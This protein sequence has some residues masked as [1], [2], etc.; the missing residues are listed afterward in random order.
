MIFFIMAQAGLGELIRDNL[1]IKGYKLPTNKILKIPSYVEDNTFI[2]TEI[3][4]V[5]LIMETINICSK[6]SGE[7]LNMDKKECLILGE[8]ERIN[9]KENM[10][11][12]K[13]EIKNIMTD[14]Q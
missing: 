12:V 3:G 2:S 13:P 9:F 8:W 6:A 11:W 1:N 4:L 10:S 5:K 7:K 14:F